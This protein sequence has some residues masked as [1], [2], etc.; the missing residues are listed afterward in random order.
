MKTVEKNWKK[1]VCQYDL[2]RVRG[3]DYLLDYNILV[4]DVTKTVSMSGPKWRWN[5]T[6]LMAMLLP[7][8]ISGNVLKK[9]VKE[10]CNFLA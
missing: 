5:L 6:S 4:H 9:V 10:L 3:R 2:Q 7:D 1:Q 8:V